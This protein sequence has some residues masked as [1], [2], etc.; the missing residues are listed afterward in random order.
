MKIRI[1][2]NEPLWKNRSVGIRDTMI[3]GDLE[4]EIGYRNKD[5]QKTFPFLYKISQEKALKYPTQ[6]INSNIILHI[7]PI[8]DLEVMS[9]DEIQE[10]NYKRAM[11]I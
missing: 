6:I 4:I 11:G 7:I 5:G 9:E 2:I 8:A 3:K 10:S 1:F